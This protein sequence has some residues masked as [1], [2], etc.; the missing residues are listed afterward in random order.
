ML[1]VPEPR[2]KREM[3]QYVGAQIRNSLIS[4]VPSELAIT[5]AERERLANSEIYKKLTG[6]F[7]EA[8]DQDDVLS[9]LKEHFYSNGIVYSTAID[10]FLLFLP[11]G[12]CY[13][14]EWLIVSDTVLLYPAGF[15]IF[16]ALISRWIAIPRARRRHLELSAEQL[17]LLKRR[18]GDFVGERFRQIVMG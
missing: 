4:L 8:I 10:V 11:F 13:V 1:K 2:W 17:D 7:W 12:F 14:I 6:V 3:D 15:L 9:K 16:V 5:P 18:K